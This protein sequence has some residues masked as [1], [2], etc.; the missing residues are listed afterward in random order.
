[1]SEGLI[2]AWYRGAWWLWL[3]WPLSLVYRAL[4]QVL[5]AFTSPPNLILYHYLWWAILV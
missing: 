2:K 4:R 5:V 3:L 1:M